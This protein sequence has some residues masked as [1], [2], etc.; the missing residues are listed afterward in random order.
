VTSLSR[1]SAGLTVSFHG[2]PVADAVVILTMSSLVAAQALR[3]AIRGSPPP[4]DD[5]RIF[6]VAARPDDA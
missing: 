5:L 4:R 2:E 3:A 1:P 6:G